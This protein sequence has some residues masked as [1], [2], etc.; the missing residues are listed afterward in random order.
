MEPNTITRLLSLS[1]SQSWVRGEKRVFP[2]GREHTYQ[3]GGWKLFEDTSKSDL[4]LEDQISSWSDVLS[5][6]PEQIQKIRALKC[7]LVLDCYLEIN[8]V[9]SPVLDSELLAALGGLGIK[10]AFNIF[11]STPD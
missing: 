10:V 2:N 4:S 5:K 7:N 3:W 8:E 1:P 11:A 9:A 6:L